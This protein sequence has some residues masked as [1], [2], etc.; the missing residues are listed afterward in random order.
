MRRPASITTIAML[1]VAAGC[2]QQDRYDDSVLSARTLK[3]QLVSVQGERDVANANLDT[4]RNQLAQAEVENSKLETRIGDLG[5]ELDTQVSKYDELLRRVSQLE[6]GPLPLEL[7]VALDNL[8]AAYPELLN[9]D[10]D[11]GLLRFSSDFT[12]DLGSAELKPDAAATIATLADILNAEQASPFELRLIGHTDNVP[13]ERL[14]TLRRHPTNVHLSV[15]RAISVRDALATAGVDPARIQVAGYGEFR[16]IV[17][18]GPKGAAQNR[19]VELLLV[20]ARDLAGR[21]A[22]ELPREQPIDEPMK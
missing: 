15:H 18:N 10:A 11:H 20:P 8:A 17:P 13:V 16:P 9:F 22:P 1:L 21:P 19:R 12:F 2:V 14:V 7:E 5:M 6:F 3:E 4:V